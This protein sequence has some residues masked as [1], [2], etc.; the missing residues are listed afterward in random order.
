MFRPL[1]ARPL[2][3]R[4]LLPSTALRI[5]RYSSPAR[6]PQNPV[7]DSA[8]RSHLESS[9]ASQSNPASCSEEKPAPATESSISPTSPTSPTSPAAAAEHLARARA[10]LEDLTARGA[11]QTRLKTD[12]AVA[13]LSKSFT[14]L[15]GEIN[16]VTGYDA[17]EALKR[18]V[19]AEETG[20]TA[21]RDAA[22][23]AKTAYD[24]AVA[25]RSHSQREVN[26]LLQRKS[27]WTDA[28]VS[29]FTQLVREDHALEQAE[30]RAKDAV[31]RSED[32]VERAFSELMRA[33]L[34]RYHEEQVWSDKI[35]SVSTY[36]SLAV[37]G[38]NLAVFLL[39]IVL[40]EPWK[41][42][43]LAQTFERKVEELET[44]NLEVVSA[45]VHALE[46]RLEA[47]EQVLAL[48]VDGGRADVTLEGKAAPS[49]QSETEAEERGHWTEQQADLAM[50]VT[51]G[52]AMNTAL[53]LG[54]VAWWLRS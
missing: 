22:K 10:Y 24:E 48:L 2:R 3:L 36:G 31:A 40:V 20:M 45:G 15:G 53:L 9:L 29:R 54:M 25:R 35:R 7:S 21:V 12:D 50:K 18:K 47:L 4:P 19:A 14:R 16:R 13:R 33:I 52:L 6:P 1:L 17:I 38:V 11:I 51:M 44:K 32:D 37:V 27:L 28:D 49:A 30:A 42:R 43:R 34:A 39:A 8:S 41:R 26:D 23:A 46:G 5:C